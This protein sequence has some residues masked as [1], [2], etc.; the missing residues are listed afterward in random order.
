M[1]AIKLLPVCISTLLLG[2]HFIR[3]GFYPVTILCISF[4]LLLFIKNKWV[5]RIIQLFLVLGAIEWLRTLYIY[6]IEREAIG[7][8]WTRLA[9][10]LG[11]VALFTGLSS[12]VFLFKSLK[13]RYHLN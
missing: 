6:A 10:I 11:S 4:P 5:A 12:L 9:V 8:S 1:N 3:F 7:E 2:A 13:N